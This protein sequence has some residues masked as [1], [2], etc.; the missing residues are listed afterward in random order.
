MAIVAL[1]DFPDA[2]VKS[3]F[4]V[5]SKLSPSAVLPSPSPTDMVVAV[6]LT[7]GG[8]SISLIV[9]V[10]DVTEP[11]EQFILLLIEMVNVSSFSS[12]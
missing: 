5:I 4:T 8:S 11:N 12:I 3:Q 7:L 2:A 6:N 1:V 10:W 9:C